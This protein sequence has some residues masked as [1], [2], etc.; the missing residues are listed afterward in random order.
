M[1]RQMSD[2]AVADGPTVHPRWYTRT[3]KV[4]FTETVTFEFFWFF[5]GQ[6][7]YA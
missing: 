3:L 5:N 4:H 7:V 2:K 6:T 1:C